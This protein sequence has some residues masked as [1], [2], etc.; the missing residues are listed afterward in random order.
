[1]LGCC[2]LAHKP[3]CLCR[4]ARDLFEIFLGQLDLGPFLCLDRAARRA[5]FLQTYHY[6]FRHRC[7]LYVC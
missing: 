1:M 4:A 7:L 5:L 2:L 6:F 3:D